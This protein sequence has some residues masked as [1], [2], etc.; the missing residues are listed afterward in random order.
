LSRFSRD[1]A[2]AS[3][4]SIPLSAA[5]IAFSA[6]VSMDSSAGRARISVTRAAPACCEDCAAGEGSCRGSHAVGCLGDADRRIIRRDRGGGMSRA[7]LGDVPMQ[8]IIFGAPG[9]VGQGVL[10]ECGMS[11]ERYRHLYRA[12]GPR[13]DP[14]RPS[15]LSQAGAGEGGYQ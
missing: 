2:A 7:I 6:A 8:V 3:V 12:D 15:R 11:E 13:H 14:C 1:I 4:G 5:T 9:M 10:R